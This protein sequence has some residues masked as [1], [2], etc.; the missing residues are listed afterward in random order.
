MLKDHDTIE[1]DSYSGSGL[2]VLCDNA[3]EEGME[4]LVYHKGHVYLAHD[5]CIEN[6]WRED[7]ETSV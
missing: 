5:M 4:G 1:I 2:C 7:E 3:V 6:K